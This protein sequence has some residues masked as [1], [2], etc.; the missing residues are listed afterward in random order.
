[1]TQAGSIFES[2]VNRDEEAAIAALRSDPALAGARDPRLGS[3][4]L[5]F[6]A[7]RG[8]GEVVNALLEAGADVR[9]RERASGTTPLHWAAEGGH[10]SV[11]RSLVERGAELE[12]VDEWFALG[13]LGWGCVVDWA[14][15][16][17]EDR[18]ITVAFLLQSGARID[19]FSAVALGRPDALGEM[20]KRDP[21]T[22]ARRLGFV[23]DGMTV[24]H[25]AAS[26]GLVDAVS[27]ALDLGADASERTATGLTALAVA[28]RA[29]HVAV[30]GLLMSRGVDDDV[31]CVVVDA[32]VAGIGTVSKELASR[33][34]FVAAE[35]GDA[36][37][38][39]ALLDR[40]A[41]PNLRMR[42]LLGEL[43]SDL[44]PLHRAAAKGKAAVARVLLDAGA[45]V[46]PDA[47][48]GLP[49]PLHLAAGAGDVE[50]VRALLD[51]GADPEATE[52]GFGATPLGWAEH[53]GRTE[54]A[55]LLRGRG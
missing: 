34:L 6:A 44:V 19:P 31:S 40:G 22:L 37:V 52:D 18:P 45:A 4:P 27:L 53:G 48:S 15:A 33:L 39:R 36:T 29:H 46:A 28:K 2:I 42:G 3:T 24:L 41:D 17:R 20:V 8:L 16:F 51:G 21:A 50:T 23:A 54:V 1:M 30:V 11:A 5:H 43:P 10:P 55:D 7:H 47:G 38:A 35:L 13:P 14:P 25:W 9:A 32:N 26:R 12:P 49:T